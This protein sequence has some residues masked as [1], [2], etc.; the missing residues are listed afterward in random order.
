MESIFKVGQKVYIAY[1]HQDYDDPALQP[2]EKT[3]DGN[4]FTCYPMDIEPK[5]YPV[6]A[7][8]TV[9]G[10]RSITIKDEGDT[11][12]SFYDPKDEG[13]VLYNLG[14]GTIIQNDSK[15]SDRE[16]SYLVEGGPMSAYNYNRKQ[17][18][19]ASKEE[20][21]ENLYKDHDTGE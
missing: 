17:Q 15:E 18:I 14:S 4:L 1:D 6:V 11:G 9:K 8:F 7:E 5:K 10:I 3:I 21:L 2:V 12:D 13:R 20:A 19:F 16:L